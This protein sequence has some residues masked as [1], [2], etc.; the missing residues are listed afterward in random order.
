MKMSAL[1][2]LLQ[3]AG[4]LHVG[5]LTA[6]GTMSKAVELRQTTLMLPPFIRRLFFVYM[7][8]IGLILAGFGSLTFLFAGEI[9]RGEPLARALCWLFAAFWA[10]R[11]LVAIFVFDVRPYLTNRLYRLGYWATNVVFVYLL[12]IYTVAACYGGTP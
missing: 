8:F 3:V 6:G 5:L 1:I 4:V 7:A 2:L 12:I 10:L 9:A 11:L